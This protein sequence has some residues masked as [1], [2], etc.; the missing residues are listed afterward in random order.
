MSLT[1]FG[2]ENSAADS[3]V[4]HEVSSGQLSGRWSIVWGGVPWRGA[5]T[6]LGLM[7]RFVSIN[8]GS[9]VGARVCRYP[10]LRKVNG[11]DNISGAAGILNH[12]DPPG[13]WSFIL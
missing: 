13:R 12:G 1:P 2:G 7:W 9:D 5:T 10:D 11:L 8:G 3:S 4:D 6:P